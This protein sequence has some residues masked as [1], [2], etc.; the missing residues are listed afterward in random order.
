MVSETWCSC[1]GTVQHPK[2][3]STISSRCCTHEATNTPCCACPAAR[4]RWHGF[5]N[6]NVQAMM[7]AVLSPAGHQPM[8][9]V[10]GQTWC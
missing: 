8:H 9:A 2:L 1:T 6:M 4:C 3:A 7:Q 10:Q 5:S